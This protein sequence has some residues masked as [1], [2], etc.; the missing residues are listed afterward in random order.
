MSDKLNIY[1]KLTFVL[2]SDEKCFGPGVALLLE[3]IEQ[4]H[5]IRSAAKDIGMAY[6]KAWKIIHR[7]EEYL[8]F[9]LV[10]SHIGGVDG[11]GAQLTQSGKHL[12]LSFR[13]C[14]RELFD[15]CEYK[16]VEHF[17]W[18]NDNSKLKK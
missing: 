3:K 8:G 18:M 7:A 12:L 16:F 6:S 1:P 5:S 10:S 9:E 2:M 17:S 13:Q 11:G 15:I 14:E 4:F